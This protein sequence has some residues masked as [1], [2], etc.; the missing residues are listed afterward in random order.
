MTTPTF[1][2]GPIR[3]PSE[4][5]SLLVRAIR[6]CTWNRCTFCPVYKGTKS[7]LRPVEEVLADVDAMAEAADVLRRRGVAAVHEGLVPREAFRCRSFWATARAGSSCRT[8]TRARSSRRSSRRSSAGCAS[9]SRPSTRVTTYGRASTLARRAPGRPRAAGEAGLTRVHLGLESGA[10]EVLMAIDKGCSSGDL[11]A[12]GGE[13]LQAG[14][15][16]C[17]YLM[18]GLGGRAAAAAHVA[19]S[20]R[21]IRAV[22][23]AAPAGRPAGRAPAHGGGGAE[24]AA[25]RREAAGEFVLPDDIEVAQELR[26]LLEQLGDARLELRSDHMLNLLTSSRARCRATVSASSP[27]WTSTS[28]GRATIRRASQSG[29]G[30]GS[31]GASPTTTTRRASAP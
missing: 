30:S 28:G 9:G 31:S 3:P 10:D 21:V 25:G 29:R 17:F 18:P 6:N 16:L 2:Q 24:H 1:E 23:A 12:G 26:D 27:C 14:L 13:V 20:A 11:I 8:R 5:H 7:S 15:E 19:G 4:A 22:G